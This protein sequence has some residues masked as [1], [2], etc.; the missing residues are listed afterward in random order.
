MC[1]QE[2]YEPVG[3]M[4]IK[5]LALPQIYIINMPSSQK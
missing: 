4:K 3:D 5:A 2:N 1:K